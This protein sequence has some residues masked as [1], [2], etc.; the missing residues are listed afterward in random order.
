MNFTML[1]NIR[2]SLTARLVVFISLLV[3]AILLLNAVVLI[4]NKNQEKEVLL[5]S[6]RA[7]QKIELKKTTELFG[8]FATKEVMKLFTEYYNY[9]LPDLGSEESFK[10]YFV[11]EMYK[12]L[13]KNEN[14]V[15]CA[16]FNVNGVWNFQYKE[17]YEGKHT[18]GKRIIDENSPGGKELL[19]RIKS[20]KPSGLIGSWTDPREGYKHQ[21]YDYIYPFVTATGHIYSIRYLAS[22]RNLEKSVDKTKRQIDAMTHKS[23]LIIVALTIFSIIIAFGVAVY[24]G[25]RITEPIKS[26]VE[27]ATIIADNNL[28]HEVELH[29]EDEVGVLADKFEEMRVSIQQLLRETA[30]KAMGLEGTLEVFSFPDLIN[31]I[32]SSQ[33]TGSLTIENP[34]AIAKIFFIQGNINH[35]EVGNL[36]GDEAVYSLFDW[37]KGMFAFKAGGASDETSVKTHWQHLLME[38]ARQTDE[39]EVIKRLIPSPY[40]ILQTVP[41]ASEQ[42]KEIKLTPAE[43]KMIV[44]IQQERVVKNIIRKSGLGELEAYKLLFSLVTGGL[45]GVKS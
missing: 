40:A 38:G 27:E 1:F 42:Q 5:A 11:K 41:Q 7:E 15:Y 3:V 32:C 8:H 16:I 25:Q 19:H 23:I 13:D 37:K 14:I 34:T 31:F 6:K 36:M 24:L 20:D 39:L 44:L 43:L 33:M 17:L 45:V 10:R 18:G 9:I 4:F 22:F 29:S 2:K 12:R 26:L 28:Q 21:V 30:K 35:A